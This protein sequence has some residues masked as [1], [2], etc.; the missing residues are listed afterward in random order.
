MF[1][2]GGR[3]SIKINKAKRSDYYWGT[4]WD[5]P[6]SGC[7]ALKTF[8]RREYQS[9]KTGVVFVSKYRWLS[10]PLLIISLSNGIIFLRQ[11]LTYITLKNQQNKF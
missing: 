2:S 10:F 9:R 5:G 1:I 6:I 11:R 8:L 7:L 3:S 4:Y